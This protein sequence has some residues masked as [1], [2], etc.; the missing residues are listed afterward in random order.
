[1]LF[2]A[3]GGWH[4]AD[5]DFGVRLQVFLI[6]AVSVRSGWAFGS[7]WK[8]GVRNNPVRYHT[9]SCWLAIT[10]PRPVLPFAAENADASGRALFRNAAFR[11]DVHPPLS[12]KLRHG[13]VSRAQTQPSGPS[14]PLHS[15]S[16]APTQPSPHPKQPNMSY[17][18]EN[19]LHDLPHIPGSLESNLLTRSGRMC[20]VKCRPIAFHKVQ[21]SS[22]RG[23][24]L[25]THT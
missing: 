9:S 12:A 21:W 22:C 16:P 19:C 8:L 7:V 17:H 15:P 24:W 1:M 25:H 5:L 10:T 2:R 23:S 18:D 4:S 3:C 20:D 14:S 11:V 6:F 13:A